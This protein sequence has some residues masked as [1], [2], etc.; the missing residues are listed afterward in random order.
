METISYISDINSEEHFLEGV[1]SSCI[2]VD[3][4]PWPSGHKGEDP[5]HKTE[6]GL[7][8]KNSV[9]CIVAHSAKYIRLN[10][11]SQIGLLCMDRIGGLVF[12]QK[13]LLNAIPG[14]SYPS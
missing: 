5:K 11:M 14:L 12:S 7:G 2:R 1:R 8:G 3:S 10:V 4:I 9:L 6:R 13:A